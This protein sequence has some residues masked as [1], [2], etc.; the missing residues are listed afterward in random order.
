M[1]RRF[2]PARI[3]HAMA[4]PSSRPRP[5]P[6]PDCQQTTS[7]PRR[8]AGVV[9][10]GGQPIPCPPTGRL[11]CSQS[12]TSK[13]R[14]SEQRAGRPP[15]VGRGLM[16]CAGSHHV[17]A[18]LSSST[19]RKRRFR[20]G[21]ASAWLKN[22]AEGSGTR[23]LGR[24]VARPAPAE[25]MP[26]LATALTSVSSPEL[27]SAVAAVVVDEPEGSL[28]LRAAPERGGPGPGPTNVRHRRR[29]AG[30]S[31]RERPG[32]CHS[33]PGSGLNPGGSVR[34]RGLHRPLTT[35]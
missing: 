5:R 27:D 1:R 25:L 20:C 18:L 15:T 11:A 14:K 2:S 24:C 33:G 22:P 12:R 29:R 4:V 7:S 35:R 6:R 3:E 30:T 26:R 28:W 13:A 10:A 23:V 16:G 31:G 9:P 17:V 32:A 34:G 19:F 8:R 21:K